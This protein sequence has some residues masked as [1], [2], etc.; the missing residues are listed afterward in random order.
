MNH[1][2]IYPIIRWNRI[3]F[4]IIFESIF[5]AYLIESRV[6]ETS[7]RLP[8]KGLSEVSLNEL[9]VKFSSPTHKYINTVPQQQRLYLNVVDLCFEKCV[10]VGWGGVSIDKSPLIHTGR[11]FYMYRWCR[12]LPPLT[13]FQLEDTWWRRDQ[14]YQTLR[15]QI[16]PSDAKSRSPLRRVPSSA[17]QQAQVG[18]HIN[19]FQC[20][21]SACKYTDIYTLTK[22]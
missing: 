8:K 21:G 15:W 12:M 9:R 11:Q 17:K 5:N 20:C 19:H 16:P 6:N 7:G 14:V 22:S 13:G 18:K 3:C 10:T 2:T 4:G 1:L